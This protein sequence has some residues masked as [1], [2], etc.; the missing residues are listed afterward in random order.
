MKRT[1]IAFGLLLLLGV[2]GLVGW[3]LLHTPEPPPVVAAPQPEPEPEPE[4]PAPELPPLEE[5]EWPEDAPRTIYGAVTDPHGNPIIGAQIRIRFEARRPDRK[6]TTDTRGE[7]RMERVEPDIATFE[8]GAE[9]A[10]GA[11]AW[12]MSSVSRNTWCGSPGLV[13]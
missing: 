5:V 6:A 4:E 8:V 2:V 3:S 1:S 11:A 13:E 9:G 7:F 12:P 10:Q